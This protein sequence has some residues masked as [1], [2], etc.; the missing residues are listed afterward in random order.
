MGKLKLD[1]P[2]VSPAVL[3]LALQEVSWETDQAQQL[4]QEFLSAKGQQLTELQKVPSFSHV[5]ECAKEQCANTCVV[6][7]LHAVPHRRCG[8]GTIGTAVRPA[9]LRAPRMTTARAS[10]S[11]GSGSPARRRPSPKSESTPTRQTRYEL[12]CMHRQIMTGYI[13]H[14]TD[15]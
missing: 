15:C 1:L 2:D 14:R 10:A 7:S 6:M 3:A 5:W 11:E 4:L 13:L 9:L 8:K 12:A